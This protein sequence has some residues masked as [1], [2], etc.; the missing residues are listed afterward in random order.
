[1]R[2]VDIV[3]TIAITVYAIV[4]TICVC[5]DYRCHLR[6]LSLKHKVYY[7]ICLVTYMYNFPLFRLDGSTIQTSKNRFL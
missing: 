5:H 7:K 2:L 6:S 3:F 1:M 4:I